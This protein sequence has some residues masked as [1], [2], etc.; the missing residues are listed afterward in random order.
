MYDNSGTVALSATGVAVLGQTG[1]AAVVVIA[2]LLLV[3]TSLVIK[4]AHRTAGDL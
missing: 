4:A 3:A 2:A 1:G